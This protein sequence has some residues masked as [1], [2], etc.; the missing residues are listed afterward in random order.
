[1]VSGGV[2]FGWTGGFDYK[3]RELREFGSFREFAVFFLDAGAGE[4]FAQEGRWRWSVGALQKLIRLWSENRAV[5]EGCGWISRARVSGRAV[6]AGVPCRA[7]FPAVRV[8]SSVLCKLCSLRPLS[9]PRSRRSRPSHLR[10]GCKTA[11]SGQGRAAS[12]RGASE[13]LPASTVLR[14][15][16]AHGR[17]RGNEDPRFPLVSFERF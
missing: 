15:P 4:Y 11:R 12:R 1:L 13:P 3:C 9:C 17:F 10:S 8:V 5:L 16:K 14:S 7:R 2:E 6:E